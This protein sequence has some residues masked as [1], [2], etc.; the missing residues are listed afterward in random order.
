MCVPDGAYGVVKQVFWN[1]YLVSWK[2]GYDTFGELHF[3]GKSCVKPLRLTWKSDNCHTADQKTDNNIKVVKQ[4]FYEVGDKVKIVDKW[5]GT[6]SSDGR[7]DKWLGKVMTIRKDVSEY[8]YRMEEDFGENCGHGWTWY[9]ED[10]EG[11]VVE[12]TEPESKSTKID[13]ELH[14]GDTVEFRNETKH[15]VLPIFYPPVGTKGTVVQ[16][17]GDNVWVQWEKGSAFHD[18][19][20]SVIREDV[21]KI[22]DEPTYKFEVGD[23]VIG[24]QK[25]NETEPVC[26]MGWIGIVERTM[27]NS[28]QATPYGEECGVGYH[29]KSISQQYTGLLL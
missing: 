8:I 9:Y 21:K 29:L 20:W 27:E 1:G 10:I 23:L 5:R 28:F 7:V 22:T 6:H 14:V 2:A 18:D 17:N 11:K 4:D 19:C 24:N 13:P 15:N 16:I 12:D 3:I 26:K 25:A